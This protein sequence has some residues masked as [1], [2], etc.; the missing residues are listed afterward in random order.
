MI[1]NV[2]TT[3][4]IYVNKAMVWWPIVTFPV[5]YLWISPM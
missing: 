2:L 3:W 1:A 4:R 5:H